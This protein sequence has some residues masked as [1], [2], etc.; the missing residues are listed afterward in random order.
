MTDYLQD[1]VEAAKHFGHFD[2]FDQ[3]I[4]RAIASWQELNK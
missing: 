1:K 2:E 4:Q 3:G